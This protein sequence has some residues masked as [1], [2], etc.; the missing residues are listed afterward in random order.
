MV[1]YYVLTL[2]NFD[3]S[4]QE[5]SNNQQVGF[6]NMR[7]CDAITK[8]SKTS[9]Q[10]LS[11]YIKYDLISESISKKKGR[12]YGYT[13]PFEQFISIDE[14]LFYYCKTNNILIFKSPKDVFSNFIRCFKRDIVLKFDK[15]DVDFD[16]II[17]NANA[18]GIQGM[19]LGKIPDLHINALGLLGNKIESSEQYKDLKAQ[20]AVVSNLTIIYN[21]NGIQEKIMIT[22]D[23]GIILYHRK[24]ESDAL[25]LVRDVYEKLFL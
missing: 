20:G 12:A 3:T 1:P 15:I 2:K 10:I 11:G 5:Y 8:F 23:G 17:S 18:I 6:E 25:E 13:D 16:D 22:K 19:W 4:L 21:Y 7:D 14:N 24:E 9:I